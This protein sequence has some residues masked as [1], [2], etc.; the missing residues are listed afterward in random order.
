MEI[1]ETGIEE[2]RIAALEKKVRDLE[3]LVRGIT[4]ELLDLKTFFPA[5]TR[6]NAEQIRQGRERGPDML[7]TVPPEPAGSSAP[8]VSED[9]SEGSTVIISRSARRPAGPEVP[10]EPAMARIMQSDGTMKMEIRSGAAKTVDTSTAS[11]RTRKSTFPK[12]NT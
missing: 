6:Q 5:M 3:P 7:K 10:P 2:V 4:A 11:E 9:R 12:K 8:P 1:Y